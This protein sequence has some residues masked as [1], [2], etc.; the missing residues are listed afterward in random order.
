MPKLSYITPYG[1]VTI[2]RSIMKS[3]G[4]DC[5]SEIFIE[6]RENRLILKKLENCGGKNASFWQLPVSSWQRASK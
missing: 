6:V 1:Q 4:I 3:L 2:P 5:G